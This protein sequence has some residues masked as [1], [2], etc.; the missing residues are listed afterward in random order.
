MDKRITLVFTIVL[1]IFFTFSTNGFSQNQ[2]EKS[3][4][5]IVK[6]SLKNDHIRS[7][8]NHSSSSHFVH[9]GSFES[10][11]ISGIMQG[12]LFVTY[13]AIIGNYSAENHLYNNLSNYPYCDKSISGN[14]E[15]ANTDPPSG[16]IFRVDLADQFLYNNE[17]L[18]GNHLKFKIRPFQ[19]FYLQADYFRLTEKNRTFNEYSDLSLF[20]FNLCYDRIR[21]EKFNMGWTLGCN[22]IGSDVM[23]AGFSYGL[24]T[25]LF[26][27]K[28]FSLNGSAK[29]SLINQAHVNEFEFQGKYHLKRCFL[30]LGYEHLII[31][32]PTYD[33]ISMGGGIYL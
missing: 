19:Y 24:N 3:K 30:S 26:V 8:Q 33:F 4:K 2:I 12:F 7:K 31:G 23:K 14:Y 32:A 17:S 29:W 13:Y 27:T 9:D 20:N 18:Y 28:N 1:L 22:Y 5:E 16:K 25:E 11:I 21:L 6:G 10:M 15:S